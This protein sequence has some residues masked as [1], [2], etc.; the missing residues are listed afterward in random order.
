[1]LLELRTVSRKT[2]GDGRLEISGESARRLAPFGEPLTVRVGDEAEVVGAG[3]VTSMRCTCEKGGGE[4][5]GHEHHFLAS[6]LFRAL[7][8]GETVV[9]ELL[10]RGVLH[11][12]RP[13]PL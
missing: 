2:P 5:G 12:A 6:D 4:A 1:M 3:H 8:P 7:V 11:V 9:I 13:H 10:D